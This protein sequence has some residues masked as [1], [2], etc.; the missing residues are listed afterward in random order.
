MARA[1]PA[2]QTVICPEVASPPFVDATPLSDV[3]P[4]RTSPSAMSNGRS[5]R[6]FTLCLALRS[7]SAT[8]IVCDASRLRVD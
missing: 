3:T 4:R 8:Q 1:S 7:C 6:A 5:G 2:E